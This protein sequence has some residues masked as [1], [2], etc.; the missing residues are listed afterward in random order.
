[1]KLNNDELEF[2]SAWAREEWEPE[3]YGQPAASAPACSQGHRGAP[4]RFDQS[5]DALGRQEGS[6]HS[7]GG[8]EFA[9][10]LALGVAG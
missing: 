5:L 7:A 4:D 3:C 8:D 10:A 1:M 2:L 9:A 6:G